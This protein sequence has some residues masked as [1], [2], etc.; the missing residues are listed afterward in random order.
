MNVWRN[1]E[2]KVVWK[3]RKHERNQIFTLLNPIVSVYIQFLDLERGHDEVTGSN[4][5]GTE[6]LYDED[7][8]LYELR[9]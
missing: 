9:A 5:E 8:K 4:M 3:G 2:A 6:N 1:A 7:S